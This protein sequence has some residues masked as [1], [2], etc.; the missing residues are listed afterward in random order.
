MKRTNTL[1]MLVGALLIAAPSA[2]AF[3]LGDGTKGHDAGE[4]TRKAED[5]RNTLHNLGDTI[6]GFNNPNLQAGA[7]SNNGEVCVFCHTPHGANLGAPGSAPLWNRT[8][9]ASAG[10]TTYNSPNMDSVPGQPKGVSLACL[11]CHDGTIAVDSLINMP[12]SGGFVAANLTPPGGTLQLVDPQAGSALLEAAGAGEASMDETQRTDAGPNYGTIT[13][14]AA[15]FPNLTTNLS[16]DHAISMSMQSGGNPYP[17]F[18]NTTA[19]DDGNIT[20]VSRAGDPNTYYEDKRDA[21]R[22]YPA[23]GGAVNAGDRSDWVECASC[24]NPHAPRPLF[25][26]LPGPGGT[27]LASMPSGGGAVVVDD[28]IGAGS[29]TQ[30]IADNPNAGSAICLSCHEK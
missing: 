30:L 12:G 23:D 13:G 14:G 7:V 11:S 27:G 15:P 26:R 8:V 25:L 16:D 10:Y 1:L 6:L 20:R 22:L 18:N 29:T 5:V 4:V 24:H 28:V 17:Q 21:I 2:W 9:P 19:A 3:H